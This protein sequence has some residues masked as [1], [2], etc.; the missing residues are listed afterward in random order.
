MSEVKNIESVN[1]PALFLKA[2][3]LP[4]GR[5][6]LSQH[7]ASGSERKALGTAFSVPNLIVTK[8]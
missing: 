4:S 8:E 2:G 7:C 5:Q 1:V 6:K 3:R